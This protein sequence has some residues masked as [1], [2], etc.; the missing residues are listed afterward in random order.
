MKHIITASF[1]AVLFG[2]CAEFP[3]QA[4]DPPKAVTTRR[5]PG[6][7]SSSSTR[8]SSSRDVK[9][10]ASG[11]VAKEGPPAGRGT[12]PAGGGSSSGSR[13]PQFSA[14]E[15]GRLV[16]AFLTTTERLDAAAVTVLAQRRPVNDQCPPATVTL[17]GGR[18]VRIHP[19][20]EPFANG[21]STRLFLDERANVVVKTL[22]KPR[23][24]H[25]RRALAVDAAFLIVL[26]GRVGLP[27]LFAIE[28]VGISDHCRARTMA[29]E[30]V[31]R[32]PLNKIKAAYADRPGLAPAVAGAIA[33]TI[34]ILAQVHSAGLVHGDIHGKNLVYADVNDVP[35]TLRLIDYG[36]A[37]P[38]V[39]A[40]GEHV[41]EG[42]PATPYGDWSKALLSPWEI[43][44]LRLT[45]RDDMFRTAELALKLGGF[46]SAYTQALTVLETA[47][48]S[49][50]K[51]WR[52]DAKARYIRGVLE[53]KRNR[54]FI[55]SPNRPTPRVFIDFYLYT[56]T[57]AFEE[58]PDYARWITA[59]SGV[60]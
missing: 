28:A 26:S 46:D 11:T 38:F 20:S 49:Q 51:Q 17:T 53:L 36:R 4:A 18:K 12:T 44:G 47:R 7:G 23:K 39:D 45:R 10:G 59:F 54:P 56:L 30:F 31:G 2:G 8:S 6:S 58:T 41:R 3:P 57:L 60:Q 21:S 40:N 9:P 1:V 27:R 55:D 14:S 37:E 42:R 52:T 32:Y 15:A 35:G 25:L 13:I 34:E 48:V 22:D 43:E 16:T 50:E 29:T 5:R 19:N 24:P 33:K